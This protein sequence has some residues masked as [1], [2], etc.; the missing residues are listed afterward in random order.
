MF[1]VNPYKLKI[2]D[3]APDFK[4]PATDGKEYSLGDFEAP[5]LCVFFTCNHCPYALAYENR[6]MQ[7]ADEFAEKVAFVAINSNDSEQYPEDSFEEMKKRENK[8]EFNYKYL[9]DETQEVAH[10][11]GGHCTPHFF[12][13]D[14]DRKLQ[15][16]GRLD[17]NWQDPRNA[18]KH[19]LQDAITHLLKGKKPLHKVTHAMGCSIKWKKK[20]GFFH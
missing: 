10:A 5:L 14:K 9:R 13:F 1:G 4:L 16:Q 17:N 2:G 7:L 6:V 18:T 3:P 19:E 15:Y 8:E 20:P 11:Y 12:L